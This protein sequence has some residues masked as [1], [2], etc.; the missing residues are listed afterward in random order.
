MAKAIK[1][2]NNTFLDSTG[3]VHNRQIL[4]DIL[5]PVGSIYISVNNTNPAT[6]Y[7]GT[8]EQIEGRFLIG[9]GKAK[10]SRNEEKTFTAGST[11]GE[12]NHKLTGGEMPEHSHPLNGGANT[13]ENVYISDNAQFK[14]TGQSGGYGLKGTYNWTGTQGN[15]EPHNNLPPY[16]A[17]YI[18]KRIS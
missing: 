7:G 9:A 12:F 3:I 15:S 8:W 17:V 2:K 1:L 13:Y 14:V 11:G 16:L 4:A 10:D 6:Y 5:Y 18:W